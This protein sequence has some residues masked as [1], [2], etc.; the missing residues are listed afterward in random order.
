MAK[1]KPSTASRGAGAKAG[2]ATQAAAAATGTGPMRFRRAVAHPGFLAFT[3]ALIAL[4]AVALGIEAMPE[5]GEP[6]EGLLEGFFALSSVWFVLEIAL[7]M[8]AQGKPWTGFFRDGW[9]TF[10]TAVV[11]LSLLPLAGGIAILARVLRL[12]RLFRLVSGSDLLRG[13]VVRRLPMGHH[14]LAATLVLALA[15]YVFALAGFHVAGG[16]LANDGPWADLPGALRSTL[17]WSLPLS[18]PALPS[19][20]A[21]GITWAIALGA[22]LLAWLGL[23]LRGLFGSR[24]QP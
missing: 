23:T 1:T 12:L 13:F 11:V 20:G 17:A 14:A 21:A 19:S 6:L 10:D 22:T 9:N 4:N 16:V 3:H 5:F 8:A 2:A 15:L 24:A 18:P 7:R